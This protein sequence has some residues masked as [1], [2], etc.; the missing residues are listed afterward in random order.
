MRVA[1]LVLVLANLGFAAWHAWFSAPEIIVRPIRPDA[2]SIQLYADARTQ[3]AVSAQ[4]E[5]GPDS[6]ASARRTQE[7]IS[8]ISIGPL[9]NRVDVDDAMRILSA[10]G[11]R[12]TQRVSPGEVWLGRWV[13]IDAIDTQAEANEIVDRLAQNGIE[14][15]YVIADGNNG[16]IVSLGVFSVAARARQR[17]ADAQ[18]LGY[19]PTVTDRTQPGEVFWLD[20][21]VPGQAQFTIPDLPVLSVNPAPRY[22]DCPAEAND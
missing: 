5:P 12:S 17:F 22:E 16:N 4:A 14:E 15:A 6:S 20:V 9:S 21:T 1:F 10:G 3:G 11:F 18:A 19:M 7:R 2:A 13:Y 8:C